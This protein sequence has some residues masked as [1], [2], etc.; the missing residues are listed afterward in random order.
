MW[1]HGAAIRPVPEYAK[2]SPRALDA[3]REVFAAE[4]DE[5]DTEQF[6]AEAFE[7]LEGSQPALA[8]RVNAALREEHDETILA[9]AYFLVLAVWLAFEEE[10]GDGL[11][12]ISTEGI[13][14]TADLLNLEEEIGLVTAAGTPGVEDAVASEQP[15]VL[16]FIRDQMATALEVHSMEVTQLQGVFRALLLEV[17]AL[18]YAVIEPSGYPVDKQSLPA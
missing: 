10:H 17:L 11:G 13:E 15:A 9:L 12:E 1:T 16:G 8:E 14:L 4:N 6:L 2:V 7:H 18:S 3:I 5:S